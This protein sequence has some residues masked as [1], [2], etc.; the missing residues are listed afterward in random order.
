MLM[1][2]KYTLKISQSPPTSLSQWHI[3]MSQI[4][5]ET[6]QVSLDI[7]ETSTKFLLGGYPSWHKFQGVSKAMLDMHESA[8]FF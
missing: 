4:S 7:C 2:F 8:V 1:G 6:F 3:F 5:K